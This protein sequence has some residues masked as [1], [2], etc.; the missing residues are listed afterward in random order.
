MSR[1]LPP[2]WSVGACIFRLLLAV[3]ACGTAAPAD[4]G[5]AEDETFAAFEWFCL[6]HLNKSG[7]IPGLF[8]AI[9]V[10]R[11]PEDYARAFLAGH[12][13]S[14]WFLPGSDA[15]PVVALT[16]KGACGV[17]NPD[18]DGIELKRIFESLLRNR[19]LNSDQIGSETTTA[20]AVTYPDKLGGP[21]IHAVVLMTTS[22]L[23]SVK[24][25]NLSAVLER[26]MAP[27]G[28]RGMPA[29]LDNL[30]TGLN[31]IALGLA[32]ALTVNA[33]R[34]TELQLSIWN[35]QKP[36]MVR[37]MAGTSAIFS[38]ATILGI[39][40][41]GYHWLGFPAWMRWIVG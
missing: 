36:W 17:I 29:M 14:A 34:Q 8:D 11:L 24:G 39:Y 33:Y 3:C 7:E 19:L 22:V 2:H 4:A 16:D 37:S 25:V 28:L 1:C 31:V 9:G 6:A 5:P 23:T 10:N 30:I 13:G 38:L 12:S 21:D 35:N 40:W 32:A 26:I 15:K 41:A 18:I 27:E 20:Y